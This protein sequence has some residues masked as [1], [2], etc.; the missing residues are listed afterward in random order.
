MGWTYYQNGTHI[1][2]VQLAQIIQLDQIIEPE[3][4]GQKESNTL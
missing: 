1:T 4:A 2:C 3:G